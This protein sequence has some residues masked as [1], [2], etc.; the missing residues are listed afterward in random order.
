M[1]INVYPLQCLYNQNHDQPNE[2]WSYI[3]EI[4]DTPL[5][6]LNDF[7]NSS[8]IMAA[9]V[10]ASAGSKNFAK[11]ETKIRNCNSTILGFSA[12]LRNES[13]KYDDFGKS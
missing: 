4:C 1:G 7:D 6:K 2:F 12:V 13:L 10:N 5:M 8:D 9:Y 3:S 11:Y